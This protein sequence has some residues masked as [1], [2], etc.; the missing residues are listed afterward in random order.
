MVKVLYATLALLLLSLGG[1]L[2]ARQNPLAPVPPAASQEAQP[3]TTPLQN[4][5]PETP[6]PEN[7]VPAA[8]VPDNPPPV[9]DP[10]VVTPKPPLA[11][12]VPIEPPSNGVAAKEPIEELWRDPG[13]VRSRNLFYGAGG[14]KHEPHGSFTFIEED[15]EG[16]NPKFVVTD[17]D[18][19][20]WKVKTGTEAQPETAAAR[21]LWA[22]GYYTSEDYYVPEIHVLNMP[23]K[24]KRGKEYVEPGGVVRGVRMKRALPGEKKLGLWKWT[25]N[26]F[27][28]TR[29][30][31]G[32]RV[33]MA[34]MN[35]WDLKDINNSVYM[36]KNPGGDLPPKVYMVSDLGASFGTTGFNPSHKIS[37]GNLD[38]YKDSK[39]VDSS[40]AQDVSFNVPTRPALIV[41]LNP[42]EFASRLPMRSIGQHIPIE[43]VRWIAQILH[44]LSVE[45][46]RDAFRAAG[47]DK[48]LVD[49]FANVVARRIAQLEQF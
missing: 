2:P 26:P 3:P 40:T 4:V 44:Q 25:D 9:S 31:N 15:M 39:F 16:T 36:V 42:K 41:A 49:G 14:Q 45:Q 8:P 32:L 27:T 17:Q 5:P 22:A 48:E 20:K 28:G 12:P 10:G 7:A 30:M 38:S 47:Y 23:A 35:N 24:L 34:V 6:A 13:D 29:Q 33:M 46:I 19:V 1:S 37:K 11:I 21:L 43:D 18:G